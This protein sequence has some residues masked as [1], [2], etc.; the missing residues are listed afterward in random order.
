[1][2]YAFKQRIKSAKGIIINE[3]SIRLLF[4][5]YI[6]EGKNVDNLVIC[7]EANY[8]SVQIDAPDAYK[9]R[10]YFD[11]SDKLKDFVV[12]YSPIAEIERNEETCLKLIE[13]N[14][15][16]SIAELMQYY[17]IQYGS[18]TRRE[19]DYILNHWYK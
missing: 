14:L 1:M 18:L 12:E 16:G 3:D 19:L 2:N 10:L 5:D 9:Y 15:I 7:K 13:Q 8:Y 11:K 17:I 6:E 4:R